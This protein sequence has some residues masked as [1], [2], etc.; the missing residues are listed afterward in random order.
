MGSHRVGHN[1]IDLA[2]AAGKEFAYSMGD[3]SSI[4]GLGR[5]PGEGKGYP[6]QYSGLENFMDWIAHE[7]TKSRTQLSNFHFHF[8]SWCNGYHTVFYLCGVGGG[9]ASGINRKL[10]LIDSNYYCHRFSSFSV[11]MI[12]LAT[13]TSVRFRVS[14]LLFIRLP[15]T[16]DST[17][18]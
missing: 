14:L 13:F 6:F 3:L 7:V 4:P 12:H 18:F 2:A 5:S 17:D 16:P 8:L 15:F 10:E 11:R 1:W 9:M